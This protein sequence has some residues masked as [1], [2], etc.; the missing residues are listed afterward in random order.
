MF[1][2]IRSEFKSFAKIGTAFHSQEGSGQNSNVYKKKGKNSSGRKDKV[3][4]P[5]LKKTGP[6][7]QCLEG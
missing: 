7:F 3:R 5:K 2:R 6:E 4:I 1:E